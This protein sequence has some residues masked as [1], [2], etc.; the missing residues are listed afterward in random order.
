[1]EIHGG[2]YTGRVKA[3]SFAYLPPKLE[4]PQALIVHP[5]R[6][7]HTPFSSRRGARFAHRSILKMNLCLTS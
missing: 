7:E 3:G 2:S 1:M 5:A 4:Y 6:A